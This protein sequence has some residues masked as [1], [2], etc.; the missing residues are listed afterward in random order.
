MFPILAKNTP[1]GEELRLISKL[2]L[3]IPGTVL[4]NI[5]SRF[6]GKP[7]DW[8]SLGAENATSPACNRPHKEDAPRPPFIPNAHTPVSPG[9]HY[10]WPHRGHL[11]QAQPAGPFAFRAALPPVHAGQA[12]YFGYNGNGYNFRRM[13]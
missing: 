8:K 11:A 4:T 2:A 10:P 5:I 9:P 7:P 6:I 13:A 12:G 1:T 3:I